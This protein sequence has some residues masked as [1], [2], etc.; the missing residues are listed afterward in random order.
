MEQPFRNC[1][2]LPSTVTASAE[3]PPDEEQLVAR[4]H[5]LPLRNLLRSAAGLSLQ[6]QLRLG[7]VAETLRE[8]EGL[9]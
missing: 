7:V 2:M 3:L 4:L 5:D 8:Y 6:N 9:L 1:T